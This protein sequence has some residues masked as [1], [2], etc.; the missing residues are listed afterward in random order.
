[1]KKLW[2]WFLCLIGEHDWTCARS[3]GIAPTLKQL[4]SVAGFFDYAKMYCSRCGKV[5][6]HSLDWP[7]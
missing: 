5:S 6:G 1:M 2:H 3:E 7:I 4:D